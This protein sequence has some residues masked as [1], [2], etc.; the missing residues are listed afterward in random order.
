MIPLFLLFISHQ[1][2]IALLQSL[3]IGEWQLF[4]T[5]NN[6]GK[7]DKSLSDMTIE[8]HMDHRY[9]KL[10]G[11][12]WNNSKQLEYG[13]FP[14]DNGLLGH[15]VL[16]FVNEL[17]IDVF[18]DHAERERITTLDLRINPDQ[19][20]FTKGKAGKKQS[21]TIRVLNTTAM[22]VVL[23]STGSLGVDEYI[24]IRSE[25]PKPEP[26]FGK[27]HKYIVIIIIVAIV[28]FVLWLV[29]KQ[30]RSALTQQLEEA[31]GKRLK[32]IKQ[33]YD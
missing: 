25:I 5:K 21:F 9:S 30:C 32:S 31:Q 3:I 1:N 33:H 6:G 10:V 27:Y 13:V 7:V 16:V 2:P 11:S 4:S 17:R 8:I 18:A 19:T 20:I 23:T 29:L 12:V 26:L 15:F 28:Q 22:S 14:V 24:A